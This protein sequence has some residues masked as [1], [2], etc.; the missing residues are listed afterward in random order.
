L[1]ELRIHKRRALLE[2]TVAELETVKRM[3]TQGRLNLERAVTPC[4][5]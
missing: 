3:V 4:A 1:A 5:A 2:A